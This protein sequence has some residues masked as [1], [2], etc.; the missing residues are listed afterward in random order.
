MSRSTKLAGL[1]PQVRDA[2]NY[3]VDI[4]EYYG[5]PVYV[6]SG[7]RSRAEQDRLYKRYMAGQSRFPAAPPGRSAHEHGMAFD[8]VV[9]PEWLPFWDWV[10]NYVGFETRASDI[11]HAVVPNWR[12]FV[13]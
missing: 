8:S 12:D 11:V 2:A 6:T 1:V 10:R 4:A 5:A 3:A 7:L 13:R 9:P